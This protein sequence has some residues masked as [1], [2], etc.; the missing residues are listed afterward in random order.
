MRLRKILLAYALALVAVP[1]TAAAQVTTTNVPAAPTIAPPP[2]GS[3]THPP[4]HSTMDAT[5]DTYVTTRSLSGEVREVNIGEGYIVV[6]DPKRGSTRFYVGHKTRYKAD[7]DSP[8]GGKKKLTLEDFQQGQTVKVTF[9]PQN[10]SVT[11]VRVRR[12]KS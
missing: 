6:S 7:K 3:T 9:W 5:S 12:P 10:F 2:R 8:L 1:L 11:E 4:S